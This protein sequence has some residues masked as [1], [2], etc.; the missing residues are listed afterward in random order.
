M[1]NNL[2][3]IFDYD[4]NDINLNEEKNSETHL[5]E[6]DY[7]GDKP[8]EALIRFI[9]IPIKENGKI[10]GV[11]KEPYY[12][13]NWYYLKDEE[14][15]NYKFDSAST[16][17]EKCQIQSIYFAL[18]KSEDI[19]VKSMSS[20]FSMNK[21]YWSLVYI[22]DDKQSPELNGTV[23]IWRY[24]KKMKDLIEKELSIKSTYSRKEK[25]AVWD[26][27]KGKNFIL[28]LSKEV[29]S[30]KGKDVTIPSYTDCEFE[31]EISG[32]EF[33]G[34]ELKKN[35]TKSADLINKLYDEKVPD[36]SIYKY[37]EY[38]EKTLTLLD[39]VL[40]RYKNA[41]KGGYNIP[42]TT[43]AKSSDDIVDDNIDDNIDDSDISDID[44]YI[45]TVIQ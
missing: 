42:V 38:D 30:I 8:Y 25:V 15:G 23:K 26:L 12:K 13:K 33:E 10:V 40:S 4:V 29:V 34:Y 5:F 2:F 6:P 28:S 3:E 37:K 27:F 45:N 21:H 44:S 39:K 36:I 41:L 14:G 19:R 18:N 22:I 7:K 35:D 20:D 31:R 16:I 1:V 24:P 9:P 43:K 32:L 11:E 17:G